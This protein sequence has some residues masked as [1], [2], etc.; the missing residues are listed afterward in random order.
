MLFFCLLEKEAHGDRDHW[1]NAG[2]DQGNAAPEHAG[3]DKSD[4]IRVAVAAEFCLPARLL[5]RLVADELLG[6]LLQAVLVILGADRDQADKRLADD[7]LR[8]A[9]IGRDGRFFLNWRGRVRRHLRRDV[10]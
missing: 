4:K 7:L 9:W 8:A 2:S 10:A 5:G 3:Q 1:E 6:E